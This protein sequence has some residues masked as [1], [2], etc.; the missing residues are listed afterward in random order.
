MTPSHSSPPSPLGSRKRHYWLVQRM[1]AAIGVDLNAAF[2]SGDLASDDWAQ[3]VEACRNCDWVE[4]CEK[5]LAQGGEGSAAPALCM[6]RA[7][8]TALQAAQ[9]AA[10]HRSVKQQ[11]KDDRA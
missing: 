7:T 9:D 8:F 2:E 6:N 5:W 10:A 1:A 3:T 11:P 4:G